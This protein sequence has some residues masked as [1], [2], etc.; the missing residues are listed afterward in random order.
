MSCNGS[1]TK[2]TTY[3]FFDCPMTPW[4]LSQ[5]SGIF[6]KCILVGKMGYAKIFNN[7]L[8]FIVRISYIIR[9]LDWFFEFSFPFDS[10]KSSNWH[11]IFS[12]IN[13]VFNFKILWWY[14]NTSC[15]GY[16][17]NENTRFFLPWLWLHFKTMFEK[18]WVRQRK[19]SLFTHC[20]YSILQSH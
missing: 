9:K 2:T 3:R 6:P 18:Y 13:Q 16:I 19:L 4:K 15:H 1:K 12:S 17:K 10:R 20:W 11:L 8:Y 14:L 7:P 5:S